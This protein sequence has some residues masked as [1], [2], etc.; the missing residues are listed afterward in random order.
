MTLVRISNHARVKTIQIAIRK[1]A[2]SSST[3]ISPWRDLWTLPTHF[4]LLF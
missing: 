2:A 1:T 4:D 3:W